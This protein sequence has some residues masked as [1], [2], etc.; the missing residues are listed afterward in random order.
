VGISTGTGTGTSTG[1]GIGIGIG[2]QRHDRTVGVAPAA[3]ALR[4]CRIREGRPGL[5]REIS[6]G[7]SSRGLVGR[8]E[9]TDVTDQGVQVS[10]Q[11]GAVDVA[12]GLQVGQL[13]LPLL[14]GR[15]RVGF[16]V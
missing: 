11:V 10:T 14:A 4:C 6:P 16:R 9:V 3:V 8:L 12:E 1:I 5:A 13:G 15:G 7:G 2:G